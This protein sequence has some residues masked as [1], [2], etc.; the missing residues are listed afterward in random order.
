MALDCIVV[1]LPDEIVSE[2][3]TDV[4]DMHCLSLLV[5]DYRGSGT[6]VFDNVQT[7]SI[8]CRELDSGNAL[9]PQYQARYPDGVL[10][11]EIC[12]LTY[13]S[14]SSGHPRCL[15]INPLGII[16]DIVDYMP[17]YHPTEHDKLLIFLPMTHQQQRL[18]VYA[19]FWHGVPIA[20]VRPEQLMIALTT[21][22]PTLCLAPPLFYESVYDR[23]CAALAGLSPGRKRALGWARRL[24]ASLPARLAQPVRKIL[25]AKVHQGLGGQMRL[26]IT[27]MAPSKRPVLDF[28][29]EIGITVYEA[30]GMTETGVIAAN[31][32]EQRRIGSVGKPI[33]GCVITIA[34]DGGVL[35][36]RRHQTTRGHFEMDGVPILH[37]PAAPM[38]TGD[39]GQFDDQGYLYLLGRKK[40]MI[41]T[42]QGYK[43]HPERIEALL[44]DHPAISNAVIFG[45]DQKWLVALISVREPITEALRSELEGFVAQTS[46]RVV[47]GIPVAKTVLTEEQFSLA[48]G[49]LT[50][51]LKVSRPMVE[52]RFS[53]ALFGR[54]AGAIAEPTSAELERVNP[55]ILASIKRAW[56]T[57]FGKQ[58]LPLNANFFDLGG[59]SL[60]A[61]QMIA[62]IGEELDSSLNIAEFVQEQTIYKIALFLTKRR[63]SDDQLVAS[64]GVEMEEGLI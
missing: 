19:A 33:P 48:N 2:Y 30:Y 34:D 59:D 35:V 56:E 41:I 61:V 5:C 23:F 14:G 17:Q 37:D 50:R 28:F 6:A 4:I 39:I 52:R 44:H 9:H 53:Q 29:E 43:L 64:S 45:N 10:P 32:P 24:A 31:L 47:E 38:E 25:F 3:G 22:R 57:V 18:L 13:S 62:I 54:I 11:S 58:D 46:A 40:E 55:A 26:M 12:A 36:H 63:D 21:F 1:A 20:F 7:I 51:S 27:G 60:M 16:A 49:L 42:A 15:I 8:E